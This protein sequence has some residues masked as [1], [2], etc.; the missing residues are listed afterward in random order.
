[1]KNTLCDCIYKK[2]LMHTS[3]FFDFKDMWLNLCLT[4]SFDIWQQ[5]YPI[6]VLQV[7]GQV[8]WKP[9]RK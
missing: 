2:D 4:Y 7:W 9:L 1:M 8:H 3:D 6:I 5:D